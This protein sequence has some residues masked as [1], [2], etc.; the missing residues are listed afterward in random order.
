M[1]QR[2]WWVALATAAVMVAGNL[3]ARDAGE[4]PAVLLLPG[5]P[6]SLDPFK[7]KAMDPVMQRVWAASAQSLTEVVLS[8]GKRYKVTCNGFVVKPGFYVTVHHRLTAHEGAIPEL[9]QGR[10]PDRLATGLR[11][12]NIAAVNRARFINFADLAQFADSP[13]HDF[14]IYRLSLRVADSYK[15]TMFERT[16]PKLKL[17]DKL[18]WFRFVDGK[19]VRNSAGK[20]PVYDEATIIAAERRAGDGIAGFLV[21][22]K[23]LL[24]GESGSP[25]VDAAGNLVGYAV[26]QIAGSWADHLRERRGLKFSSSGGGVVADIQQVYKS[27]P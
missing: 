18:Y 3:R 19:P 10:G 4:D 14:T 8:N 11:V 7:A 15:T 21:V 20:L 17:G 1:R 26:S 9:Q 12:D 23:L 5:R 16:A 27:I 2:W 6:F 13:E 25:F 24:H 22:D